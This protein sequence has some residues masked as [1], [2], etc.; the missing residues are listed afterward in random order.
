MIILKNANYC[1]FSYPEHEH[2]CSECCLIHYGKNCNNDPIFCGETIS[3]TKERAMTN[4]GSGSQ[5]Y[6]ASRK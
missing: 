1:A 3:E 4:S 6:N 5:S 2:S